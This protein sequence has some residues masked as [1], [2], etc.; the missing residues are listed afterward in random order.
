MPTLILAST[1]P[2]RKTLLERLRVPFITA[3]PPVDERALEAEL[4]PEAPT[5]A[6]GARHLARAK[7]VSLRP[8]FPGAHILGADQVIDL[9]GEILGKPGSAER[10]VAQLERL[11][12][13]T[14]HIV[15]AVALAAPDGTVSEHV[16]THAMTM[17]RLD[18]A[19]LR[20]YVAADH[21]IDCAGSYKIESDGYFLFE[22]VVGG[23]H[24]AVI[25]LP[26]L[27]VAGLLAAAGFTVPPHA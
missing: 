13:R 19:A 16:D 9:D 11:A 1:S 12:G 25:G 21:P 26:L 7:A 14:H 8:A 2:Y 3:A 23:D 4:G 6:A 15:T 22:S 5:G 27:A 24:T 20:R 18:R 17:R 10:A